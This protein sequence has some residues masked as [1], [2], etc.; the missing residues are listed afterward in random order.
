M[1]RERFNAHIYIHIYIPIHIYLFKPF[2][3]SNYKIYT[4]KYTHNIN[5]YKRILFSFTCGINFSTF[6]VHG[7][8][9]IC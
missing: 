5:L 9:I 8:R 4:V 1:K 7:E 6:K 2:F 3:A